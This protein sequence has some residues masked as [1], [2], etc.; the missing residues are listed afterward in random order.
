MKN[1]ARFYLPWCL[2][3]LGTTG[4]TSPITLVNEIRPFYSLT[5]IYY[6]VCCALIYM[7][8]ILR[9]VVAN[10]L[11]RLHIY[12]QNLHLYFNIYRQVLYTEFGREEWTKS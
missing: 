10:L 4:A 8:C 5:T 12:L 3:L 2:S 9:L 7:S 1:A 11:Q 6:H